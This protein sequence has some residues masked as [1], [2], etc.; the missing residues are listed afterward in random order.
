MN[1]TDAIVNRIL[2][3]ASNG[4][5]CHISLAEKV[6][7]TNANTDLLREVEGYL[8]G[9][10]DFF[11]LTEKQ[12]VILYHLDLLVQCGCPYTRKGTGCFGD[13]LIYGLNA[14]SGRCV[15]CGAVVTD[16]RA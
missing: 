10:G 13:V 11:A 9:A 15:R 14:M 2:D 16:Y 7:L 1:D 5:F 6:K 4:S 12:S 8:E 3:A